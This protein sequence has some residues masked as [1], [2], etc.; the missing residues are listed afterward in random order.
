MINLCEKSEKNQSIVSEFQ[1]KLQ[2]AGYPIVPSEFLAFL[3][4]HNGILTEDYVVLGIEPM[5]KSIDLLNFNLEH[6]TPGHRLIIGYDEFVFLVYD[7]LENKYILVDRYVG[8][9][10]D[11]FEDMEAALSSIIHDE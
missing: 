4:V 11:D 10:L 9:D 3:N 8:D 2:K 7:D 5:N 1:K 6:N